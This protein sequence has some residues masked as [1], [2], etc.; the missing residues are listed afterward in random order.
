MAIDKMKKEIYE[1]YISDGFTELDIER[2]WQDT[3]YFRKKLA[4][5]LGKPEREVTS[6]T[7]EKAMRKSKKGVD[8]WFRKF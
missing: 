1:R 5:N 8:N 2:I 3:L 6:T 7:Y 4:E